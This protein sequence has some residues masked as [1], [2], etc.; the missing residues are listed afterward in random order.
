[1]RSLGRDE[2]LRALNSAIGGLLRE[3]GDVRDLADSVEDQLLALAAM[4]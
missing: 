2:L 3:A 4:R 1:V